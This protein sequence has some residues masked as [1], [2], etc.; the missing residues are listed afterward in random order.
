MP[1]DTFRVE[2]ANEIPSSFEIHFKL[3]LIDMISCHIH[4]LFQVN[5]LFKC[6]CPTLLN[7]HLPEICQLTLSLAQVF[8]FFNYFFSFSWYHLSLLSSLVMP[9]PPSCTFFS[10]PGALFLCSPDTFFSF[11]LRQCSNIEYILFC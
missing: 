5:S 1:W 10:L 4:H 6:L 9:L 7:T 3:Q 2:N 8:K 11:F